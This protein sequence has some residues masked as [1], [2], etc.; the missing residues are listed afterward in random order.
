[1]TPCHIAYAGENMTITN[2]TS[3]A[4]VMPRNQ[5]EIDA[6]VDG[7]VTEMYRRLEDEIAEELAEQN[8]STH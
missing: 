7:I 1:G 4:P 5:A 2:K 6:H 3:Q 8:E